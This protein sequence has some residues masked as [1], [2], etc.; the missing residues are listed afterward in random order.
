[1][2]PGKGY[3]INIS[4]AHQLIYPI[5]AR[6]ASVTATK[7]QSPKSLP[8]P[9]V[10]PQSMTLLARCDWA[11]AGDL[12]LAKVGDDLRGTGEL[13]D[14]EGFPAVLLQI[15]CDAADEDISLWILKPDGSQIPVSNIIRSAPQTNLGNYPDFIALN[16]Y[17]ESPDNP[18]LNNA[19]LGCYPNPFNPS[20]TISFNI[21]ED[22]TPVSLNIYN[23]RGQRIARIVD[24]NYA[25]G[26]H[27]VVWQG[28]DHNGNS[29]GSGLYIIELR[30]GNYRKIAKAM[31]AK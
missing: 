1:M 25:K 11:N 14:L 28:I 19:L 29:Q 7:E 6:L 20:T 3:W 10:L 31:L 26:K 4:D 13:V 15:Y 12:L 17:A 5:G 22:S 21:A 9:T 30:A 27:S 24:G 18:T 8:K 23:M 2:Y 16:Q